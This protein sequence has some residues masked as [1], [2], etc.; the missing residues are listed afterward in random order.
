MEILVIVVTSDHDDK[1]DQDGK[2]QFVFH[3]V[4]VFDVVQVASVCVVY[5]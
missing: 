1:A 3:V 5:S 2:E 4:E